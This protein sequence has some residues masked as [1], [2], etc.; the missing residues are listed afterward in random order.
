MSDEGYIKF[1]AQ[2]EEAPPLPAKRLAGLIHWRGVMYLH[3]L[4]GAYPDG[5]GFGNISARWNSEGQ[6]VISG[7]ATGRLPQT[8]HRHYSLVTSFDLD[9]N[10]L[11]CKGP[12]VASSESMSHA[13]IYQT[14]R[15]VNAV[16]H[17]HHLALWEKLLHAV[18]TT[19]KGATYGT[20]EMARSIIFLL[21]NTNLRE[22]KIFV[23]EGHREGIFTFG[24]DLQEATEKI[25]SFDP[26]VGEPKLNT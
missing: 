8:D 26:M 16:V 21:K 19:D 1:R 7:S 15:E 18:P 23:M 24:N 20:P 11:S 4:I 13:V 14:C 2:W 6:F 3:G 17:V 10:T 12:V 9:Q 25:L 5:T 22:Q